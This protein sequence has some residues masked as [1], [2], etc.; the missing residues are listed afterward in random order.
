MAFAKKDDWDWMIATSIAMAL[1]TIEI[2]LAS[3][4]QD[5]Y[6]ASFYFWLDLLSTVSL[7]T[8]I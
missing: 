5:G 3:I 7:I 6:F 8:D 4:G 1:F 2:I